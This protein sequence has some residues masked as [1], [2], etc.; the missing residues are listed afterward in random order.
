[1]TIIRSKLT[2]EEIANFASWDSCGKCLCLGGDDSA[3][4]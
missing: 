1:M 3:G 4:Q 2:Q